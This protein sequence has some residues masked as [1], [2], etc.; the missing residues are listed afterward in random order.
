MTIDK[1]VYINM[2][3]RTDRNDTILSELNRIG[4][5]KDRVQRFPAICYTGCANTGCLI[6]H[7]NVLEM[8]YDS[9]YSNVLILEDDF[10][11]IEDKNKVHADLKAFFDLKLEWDVVMLTT[12]GAVVSEYTN[13]LVSRISSSG[14]GAGY[15]VNRSIMLELST[16][17][18]SNVDNLF[19]TKQHWN[20]QND[21]LWKSL[22]PTSQWFMFNQYLGYQQAGYSDLSQDKKIAIVPQVVCKVAEEE[23][24][25]IQLHV[26]EIS[27]KE[28]STKEISSKEISTKEVSSTKYTADSVVNTVIESFIQRSNL[29]LQKYG[30]TLDREDLKVLDWIQHAQEE[31]MDAILYLEKLKR[32]V[33]KKGI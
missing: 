33:I 22:M 11:F 2:D 25:K 1:I 21:I 19:L 30:T 6:S 32:E 16:L 3:S 26:E 13:D 29:G 7:A 24:T 10:V 20:Y 14:N 23:D 12:C 5:P 27:S 15:L 4:F 17:F 31:H 28:I 18:K 8:A 9:G